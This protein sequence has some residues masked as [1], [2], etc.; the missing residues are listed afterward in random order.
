MDDF[1]NDFIIS[2]MFLKKVFKIYHTS[3]YKIMS[4]NLTAEKFTQKC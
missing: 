3:H 4:S 2:A 1:L